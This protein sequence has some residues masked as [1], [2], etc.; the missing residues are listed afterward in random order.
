MTEFATK[1]IR[2]IFG[3]FPRFDVLLAVSLGLTILGFVIVTMI[4]E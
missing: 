4:V 1:T 2:N 3:L